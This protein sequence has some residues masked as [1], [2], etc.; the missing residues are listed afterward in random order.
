ML[1]HLNVLWGRQALTSYGNRKT[2][3][4]CLHCGSAIVAVCAD[5]GYRIT[6][7][8]WRQHYGV[9]LSSVDTFNP[10]CPRGPLQSAPR[11]HA[12]PMAS[13]AL[14]PCCLGPWLQE[15]SLCVH[16]DV[17]G[18]HVLAGCTALNTMQVCRTAGWPPCWCATAGW[19]GGAAELGVE[20]TRGSSVGHWAG[21]DRS[22]AANARREAEGFIS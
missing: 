7:P 10:S 13:S 15:V 17:A 4:S 11:W 3:G 12:E 1:R 5:N 2:S 21:A 19:G 22:V 8:L 9:T 20:G 16:V 18:L 6:C 14:R